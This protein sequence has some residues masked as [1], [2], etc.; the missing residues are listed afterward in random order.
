MWGIH[1]PPT[2][3]QPSC[4]LFRLVRKSPPGLT[5]ECTRLIELWIVVQIRSISNMLPVSQTTRRAPKHKDGRFSDHLRNFEFDRG[6]YTSP[7][8]EIGC[9]YSQNSNWANCLILTWGSERDSKWIEILHPM[10][11]CIFSCGS[12]HRLKIF[13]HHLRNFKVAFWMRKSCSYHIFRI[14]ILNEIIHVPS[15]VALLDGGVVN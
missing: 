1:K 9:S 15:R 10:T 2:Q 4:L 7:Q 12:H 14:A 11:F 6:R 3:S 5:I 13:C 8:Y